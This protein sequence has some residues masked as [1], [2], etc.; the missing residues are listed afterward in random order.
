M[1][2]GGENVPG[3]KEP[4]ELTREERAEIKR[5]VTV[6]CANYDKRY[7][8][9]PLDGA[10]YMLLKTHIGAC[11]R[12]FKDAV[13][14]L[15]PALEASLTTAGAYSMRKICPV[16]G[17]EYIPTTSQAYCSAACAAKGRRET[18]R[19]YNRKRKKKRV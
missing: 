16:C 14:P 1:R 2:K 3:E 9:L 15:N 19:K 10:C 11:C 18:Y 4:R 6:M 13:L 7:G 12:Y 17:G 8:C 5:L